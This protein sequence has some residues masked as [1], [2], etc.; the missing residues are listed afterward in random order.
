M[1]G[2]RIQFALDHFIRDG[3]FLPMNQNYVLEEKKDLGKTELTVELDGTNLC[4]ED[5]DNKEKCSFVRQDKQNGMT[6]SVDHVLFEKKTDETWKLYLIEM[7]SS[8]GYNTWT[9]IKSKV[10]TSMLCASAIANYLGIEIGDVQAY[11]TF[12]EDKF[13]SV[14]KTANPK[15]YQIPLGEKARDAKKDE[16][17]KDEMYLKF[18]TEKKIPHSKVHVEIGADGKTFE[19]KLRLE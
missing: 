1:Y 11:T 7:K 18:G 19:G 17:D 9:D 4:I 15:R 3:Y 5:F 2:E 16:W 14:S 10:R 13:E 8:V 6:K 12:S